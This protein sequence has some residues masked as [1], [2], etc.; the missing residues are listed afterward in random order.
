MRTFWQVFRYSTIWLAQALEDGK[1]LTLELSEKHAKVIMN[2]HD[3][4]RLTRCTAGQVAEHNIRNAG[5]TLEKVEI[6]VGL[7]IDYLR[8]LQPE[9]SYD[10]VFI[11]ADK[12]SNLDYFIEAKRLTRKHGII[13]STNYIL[14]D[15]TG[16]C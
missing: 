12:Q 15:R 5:F 16:A 2:A 14:S 13:V 4:F 1:L 11:D 6:K 3:L 10:L 7:A 8:D 9:Q